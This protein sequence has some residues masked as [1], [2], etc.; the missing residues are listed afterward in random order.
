[1][2]INAEFAEK[3]IVVPKESDWVCSPES[4][5]DR[6]MLDRIG[7]FSDEHADYSVGT[8]VRNPPGSEHS[9]YSK[10]G[11]RILVKL[12]QFDP[13]DLSHVVVDTADSTAWPSLSDTGMNILKLHE[14]GN[15]RVMMMRLDKGR[16]LPI[17]SDPGGLEILVISGSII[18]E[19]DELAAET[20]LRYPAGQEN[21]VVASS[22][23]VLWVKTG[24]LPS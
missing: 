10:N 24:H 22:D 21:G 7:V 16:P 18:D 15:E 3:A 6:I 13:R 9:P 20:W 2:R 8:Y 17:E 11:C 23:S 1:V 12:R 5:V 14:F 19:D 4:G